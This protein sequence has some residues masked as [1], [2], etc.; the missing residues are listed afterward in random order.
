[1]KAVN[2]D[3]PFSRNIPTPPGPP[4]SPG[5]ARDENSA[6]T[7]NRHSAIKTEEPKCLQLSKEQK[8]L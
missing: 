1:M 2:E 3:A 6:R 4:S 8:L 7:D 5:P